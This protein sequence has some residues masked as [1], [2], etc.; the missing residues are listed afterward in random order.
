MGGGDLL[1]ILIQTVKS[2]MTGLVTKFRLY[3]NWNFIKTKI[4][5]KIRDFFSNLLGV[6][7]RN[8]YDYYTIGRWMFSKRLLYALVIIIG[9]L[10]IWYIS[11][12]TTLFR[13]FSEDGIVTYNYNSL[14]LRTAKGHVKIKGKSGYV[15]YDGDVSAGYVNGNGTLYNK[16]GGVVY[17]GTFAQNKYEG[18]GTLN[19]ESGNAKYKGSF[20]EN[21]YEGEGTLYREDG[22][23]EYVGEFSQGKKNGEGTLYDTGENE[24]YEGVFASD[25]I[26]Y[27]EMIGKT[28]ADLTES[29]KGHR[30]LYTTSYDSVGV[31]NDID[32]LYH[33]RIDSEALDDDETID[34]VYVLTDTFRYGNETINT[35]DDLEDVLGKPVYEGN[36]M[37]LLPEAISINELSKVKSVING[38]VQMEVDQT[39][40]DVAEVKS[41]DY[42]YVV[43]IHSYRKGDVMY[44][45]VGNGRD[46]AFDFYYVSGVEKG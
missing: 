13:N 26:V 3:T 34:S 29:Y 15:A 32:A 21:L 44:S 36:S 37:V 25:S 14:R 11:T 19:Y 1:G 28:V 6:K 42:S 30:D 2:K 24:L 18:I 43:Y 38:P 12:E 9:V 20:H 40:S 46:N 22:T 23:R 4:F 45:F 17:T 41:I 7:P 31:M 5:T 39:F 27:S 10:S 16:Y 33:A 8:K 35:I